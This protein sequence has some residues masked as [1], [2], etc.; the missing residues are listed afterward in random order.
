VIAVRHL[1]VVSDASRLGFRALID[2]TLTL[3]RNPNL[4]TTSAALMQIELNV[5]LYTLIN[6]LEFGVN[7]PTGT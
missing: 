4:L 1:G 6:I 3:T 7:R 2:L 5:Q